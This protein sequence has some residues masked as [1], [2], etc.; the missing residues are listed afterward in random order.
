LIAPFLL[1]RDVLA[2]RD[3]VLNQTSVPMRTE[4]NISKQRFSATRMKCQD[5][6]LMSNLI[7]NFQNETYVYFLK[8][9][10]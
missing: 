4:M 5:F 7:N 1:Q 9:K 3:A 10:P 2:A 8:Q 6:C